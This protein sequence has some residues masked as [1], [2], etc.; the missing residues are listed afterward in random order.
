MTSLL[1][2][3]ECRALINTSKSDTELQAIIDRAETLISDR[4]GAAQDENWTVTISQTVRGKGQN[5]FVRVPFAEIVSVTEDSLVLDADDYRAWG[6]SGMITRLP[7]GEEWGDVCLVIYKP[8]DQREKRKAA[9]IN[10]VRLMLEQTA[11]AS[12]SIGGEYS[13]SAPDWDKVIKQ[14]LRNLCFPVV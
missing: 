12:E 4:I 13:Y 8:V 6:D 1:T 2:I 10:L 14:E 5:L 9:T 11:M 7:E 3:A